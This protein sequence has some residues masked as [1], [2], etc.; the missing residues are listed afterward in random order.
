MYQGS[1]TL[2]YDQNVFRYQ[3][4]FLFL[5]ESVVDDYTPLASDTSISMEIMGPFHADGGT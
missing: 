2:R 4:V 5:S 3:S 1:S